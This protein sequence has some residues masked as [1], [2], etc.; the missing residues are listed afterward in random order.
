MEEPLTLPNVEDGRRTEAKE[1]ALPRLIFR[2]RHAWEKSPLDMA[3]DFI[4]EEDQLYIEVVN[5]NT[6]YLVKDST[7]FY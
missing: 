5:T 3:T 6:Q 7:V 2:T 1:D 4:L